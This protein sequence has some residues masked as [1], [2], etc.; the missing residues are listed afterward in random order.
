MFLF[1]KCFLFI[2]FYKKKATAQSSVY[3]LFFNILP[4]EADMN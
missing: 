3:R 1:L 2:Y 4:K